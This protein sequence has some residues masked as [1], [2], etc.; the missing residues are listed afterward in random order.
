[1][2]FI[3][4]V[5]A[6]KLYI[7]LSKLMHKKPNHILV[8]STSPWNDFYCPKS[9]HLTCT[10]TAIIPPKI[11][12]LGAVLGG[13]QNPHAEI[14]KF[15][16]GFRSG[17]PIH[18]W[19]FKHGRNW[20]RINVRKAVVYWCEGESIITWWY[21]RVFLAD[22]LAMIV[23]FFEDGT[24]N[25][26][27]HCGTGRVTQP[28]RQ[29]ASHRHEA[30]QNPAWIWHTTVSS[31]T[32]SGPMCIIYYNNLTIMPKLRSTYDEHLIYKT[33]HEGCK[34]FLRYDSLAIL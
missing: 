26:D 22:V 10:L 20:C 32:N 2:P 24:G 28:H 14:R 11:P 13:L 19:F 21:S 31:L 17:T 3:W 9:C 18:A 6:P 27:H 34:D 25:G 1:M 4:E 15:L 33:S 5:V 12:L 16:A 30:K 8:M 7:P 23:Q 29:K